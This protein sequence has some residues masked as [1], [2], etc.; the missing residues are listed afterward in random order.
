[1]TS[2]FANNRRKVL[3]HVASVVLLPSTFAVMSLAGRA[4][5][6]KK[7]KTWSRLMADPPDG[8]LQDTLDYVLAFTVAHEGNTPFMY[9]NWPLKNPNLDVTVGVGR[10][11]PNA[12]SAAVPEVRDTFTVKATGA[13]A[14]DDDMRAE[15]NRVAAI[16]RSAT[17]LFS[18]YRDAS[19]L[20]MD[21][22]GMLAL[23]GDNML[24]FWGQKGQD[25][26][27]SAIPA[28]AQVA[29]MSYNYGRRLSNAPKMCNAVRSS[30]FDTAATECVISGWDQRKNQ[31]H[32]V[33]FQ[34]AGA[35]IAKGLDLN[36]LPPIDGPFKPPPSV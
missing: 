27:F 4:Q 34:N 19:P 15:W 13:P 33:L 12:D 26:D 18:D 8:M 21:P 16:P 10:A 31:A 28:Q 7:R 24:R 29:L 14:T 25:F 30:D 35:I 6:Q 1:M 32:Q 2:K 23:L 9:N 20:L 17:N 5:T 3:Q 22:D 11:L 36:T